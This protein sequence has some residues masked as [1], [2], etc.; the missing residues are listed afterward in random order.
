MQVNF[1]NAVLGKI[2]ARTAIENI[3]KD[4]KEIL[5]RNNN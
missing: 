3:E 4:L 5:L 2:S 1:T